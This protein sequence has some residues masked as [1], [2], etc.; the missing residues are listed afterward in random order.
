V[1]DTTIPVI[2][3]VGANPQTIE[4][5]APYVELGA[6]AVDNIDGDISGSIVVDASAVNAGL[7]GSYAVTYDVVDSEGNAVQVVRIVEVVDTTVPVITMLGVTPVTIEVGSTYV[8]AGATAA[9]SYDGDLTGSIVTVN[10]VNSAVVGS[11]TVTY[12]V[13]DANG[14][15]AAQ[16][17]R[18]VAVVDSAVPVI[19]L[20]GANPQTIEAG[21][22]YVELGAT[23]ADS[24]DGDI[25]ASIVRDATAVDAAVVGSYVVTYDVTDSSG[26]E[27][28]QVTRTVNVVDTTIP[29]ISLLGTSPITVELGSPYGDAGATA[30]DLADGDI[31]GSIVTVNLVDTSVAGSYIITYNVTDSSGNVAVQVT[32]TVT[33]VD[34]PAPPNSNPIAGNDAYSV[35]EGATLTVAASGIL[36]NDTDVDRDPMTASLITTP[37]RGIV[38]L[39]AD[40]SF[41]YT[42][43]AGDATDDSFT[44]RV[45]DGRGGQDTA[46]VTIE[47]IEVNLPPIAATDE[48]VVAEDTRITIEPLAND[49]DP[50]GLG[51]TLVSVGSANSGTVGSIGSTSFSY[52]PAFNFFGSLELV[53]TVAD[54]A[55]NTA[56]GRINVTVFPVNDIPE[57]NPE[58]V[59][60]SSYEGIL[61]DVLA[62]DSDVDGDELYLVSATSAEHGLVEVLDSGFI[63]YTPDIGYVGVDTIV[64]SISDGHGGT[65][66]GV[67]TVEVLSAALSAANALA[68]RL[69]IN[70][71]AVEAAPALFDAEPP[72]LT[73]FAGVSLLADSFFQSV[74]ALQVPLIFLGIAAAAA[75]F[76]GRSPGMPLLAARRR[77][78]WAV[79]MIEREQSLKVHE[80][81][82]RDSEIISKLG[83][84]AGAILATGRPKVLD[85]VS[86]IE[87]EG[88]GSRGWVEAE[89]LTEEVDLATFMED[90][91]P[92][93]MV[94]R[95]A[96]ELAGKSRVGSLLGPRGLAISVDRSLVHVTAEEA[97]RQEFPAVGGP[98]A[99]RFDGADVVASFLSAY[100]HTEHVSPKTP[101][102]SSALIPTPL[103]NFHYLAVP[104]I[105]SDVPWL[106]YFEYRHGK[107]V[108][109]AL[110]ADW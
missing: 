5:G 98:N 91:R 18:T 6:T 82:S 58:E 55:G 54:P 81:P 11:Y 44:Y 45:D 13:T 34:T 78:H 90:H 104:G 60:T 26:N 105:D 50:E 10:L 30:Y 33:V 101:H 35:D 8:D 103:W 27:A 110:G 4:V 2:T 16:V 80:E 21:L 15:A 47:V 42:H 92:A 109:V 89:Y 9:D 36:G 64:Y 61:I 95:L 39:N 46:V 38:E 108:I 7:V 1:V 72:V 56:S 3:L 85:G 70:R 74:V 31:T 71:L 49:I 75:L 57:A 68:E 24:Y 43:T 41:V 96:A 17:A 20:V 22:P 53:Y 59:A 84:T 65:A 87:I 79:V 66:V 52:Q 32:R 99:G 69:G 86:W 97:G 51:L 100:A 25:T 77:R 93:A 107:P 14:N 83:S 62:N 48:V 73:M 12:D 23:A 29:V 19:T 63:Q 102:S 28:V 76:F 37:L 67:V 40:G 88:D 94:N 106:V